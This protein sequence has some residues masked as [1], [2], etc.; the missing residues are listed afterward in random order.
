[1]N[2]G[3]I[4]LHESPESRVILM[5]DQDHVIF[6]DFVN[7]VSVTMA[8]TGEGIILDL[9]EMEHDG[10]DLSVSSIGWEWCDLADM[11]RQRSGE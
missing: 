1:M 3:P 9:F 8:I 7:M 5:P 6:E 4:Y 11:L 10:H 2:D